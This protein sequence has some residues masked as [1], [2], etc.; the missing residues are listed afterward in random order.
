MTADAFPEKPFPKELLKALGAAGISMAGM[1]ATLLEGGSR[2]S[3]YRVQNKA[4]ADVT[5]RLC[6]S[7][8]INA[9][10]ARQEVNNQMAAHRHG[11]AAPVLYADPDL[12]TL[13]YQFLPGRR[14]RG[15]DFRDPGVRQQAFALLRKLHEIPEPFLHTHNYLRSLRQRASGQLPTLKKTHRKDMA[16]TLSPV[17]RAVRALEKAPCSFTPTH[18]DMLPSNIILLDGGGMC[19]IDFEMSGMGDPHE[20]VANLIWGADLSVAEAEHAMACYFGEVP[21]AAKARIILYLA[22]IPFYWVLKIHQTIAEQRAQGE[23]TTRAKKSFRQRLREIRKIVFSNG[24]EKSLIVMKRQAGIVMKCQAG[25][26]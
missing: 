6:G 17:G 20:D 12:G 22:I 15:K 25:R 21:I 2:N 13:V 23:D 9:A 1:S 19:F 14:L 7:G 5:V 18:A 10:H 4:G 8:S 26:R 11:L 16:T 24:Y 3:L